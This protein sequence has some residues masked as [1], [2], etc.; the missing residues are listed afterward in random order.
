MYT[1]LETE[2]ALYPN[3]KYNV[4]N[5]LF[6]LEYDFS[7]YQTVTESCGLLPDFDQ[8]DQGDQTCVGQEGVALSGG[9][10]ARIG[11]A[12]A[13]YRKPTLVILD[14]PLSAVDRHVAKL[15][16]NNAVRELL[17]AQ[18][19]SVLMATHQLIFIPPFPVRKVSIYKQVQNTLK[20][21]P[22][23]S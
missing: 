1:T 15:I 20:Q 8:F 18:D 12:R 6:G 11:L 5:I 9:Q 7:W 17:R 16:W 2:Q 10:R 21:E 19:I 23:R 3:F 22:Q 13:I 14:D 4:E